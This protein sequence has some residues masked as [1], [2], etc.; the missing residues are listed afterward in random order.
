MLSRRHN[1]DDHHEKHAAKHLEVF[2][3]KAAAKIHIRIMSWAGE[4][5]YTK[6]VLGRTFEALVALNNIRH[7]NVRLLVYWFEPSNP[8]PAPWKVM[9][10]P[11]GRSRIHD[12]YSD[13]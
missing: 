5:I 9:S 2:I 4:A 7:S 10:R 12:G 13:W 1:D 8:D 3:R 6:V 11:Q